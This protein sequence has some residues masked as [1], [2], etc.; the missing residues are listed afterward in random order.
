MDLQNYFYAILF[1]AKLQHFCWY[2]HRGHL[3][4]ILYKRICLLSV[5][6]VPHC[7]LAMRAFDG[8]KLT[9][10]CWTDWIRSSTGSQFS[11]IICGTSAT[12][13]W[14]YLTVV[15]GLFSNIDS[16]KKMK[17]ELTSSIRMG[18]INMQSYRSHFNN[19]R[20]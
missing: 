6:P 14:I 12:L 1:I 18:C 5:H 3:N 2:S 16:F 20:N 7:H 13:Q 17:Y 9:L 11:R 15:E 19:V 8:T 4:K 10:K